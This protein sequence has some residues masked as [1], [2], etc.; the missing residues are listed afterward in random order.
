MW[1]ILGLTGLCFFACLAL[2][3]TATSQD[4]DLVKQARSLAFNAHRAEALEI[5]DRRLEEKPTDSDARVLYG[6]ILSWEGRYEEA[7][8]ELQRVLAEHPGHGD[9][10]PALIN[11]ELWSDHPE[12][13]EALAR[14]G[15]RG[16]PTDS[17]LLIARVRGLRKLNQNQE[18][19][20]TLNRL[21]E[22]D[23][24][25]KEALEIRR[26]M[27][28]VSRQWES[29]LGQSYEWFSDRRSAWSEMQLS[30]RRL[31][32]A[33]SLIGRLSRANRF[34]LNSNQ[35]ELDFYPRFRPGTY[36]YVNVGYSP[37]STLYP[38]YR[39]GTDLYQSLGRGWEGSVGYRRLGFAGRVN[40]Y[41]GSVAKYYGDWLFT[42]RFFV[43][44]D[45]VGTSVSTHFSVRHYFSNGI[46]YMGFRIG[47]GSSPTE[48]HSLNDIEV[49][50]S[51]TYYG[52]INRSL[53]RRW[54]F[55]FRGGTS[56]EERVQL[57]NLSRYSVDSTLYL[58][59]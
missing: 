56:Q 14:E 20:H 19:I 36:G 37:D 54:A 34:S 9:A 6:L 32:P 12:R 49:L 29:S 24:R 51:A 26:G 2:P 43:T 47:R 8:A 58:K 1:R 31:T 38:T 27:Q 16:R 7:R 13:A 15:L 53:S 59:F 57:S 21:L 50:N 10:L 25:N 42:T 23:P 35:M 11:V 39:F 48:I 41:T 45:S 44:P 55:G 40:I 30:L 28:E 4:E 18:A 5:L 3:T 46:D 17:S 22:I 52:E 33:G